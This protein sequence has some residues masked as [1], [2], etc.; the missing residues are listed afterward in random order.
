[1]MLQ[2]FKNMTDLIYRIEDGLIVNGADILKEVKT[3]MADYK[4]AQYYDTGY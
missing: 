4:S 1:M 2:V 3:A